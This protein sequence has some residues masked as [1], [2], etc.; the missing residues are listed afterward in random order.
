MCVGG[1]EEGVCGA[2]LYRGMYLEVRVQLCELPSSLPSL[3]EIELDLSG[4]VSSALHLTGPMP[5]LKDCAHLANSCRNI[6]WELNGHSSK[7]DS[8]AR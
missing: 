5:I 6:F 4:F 2:C 3:C 1:G 8:K 7:Q